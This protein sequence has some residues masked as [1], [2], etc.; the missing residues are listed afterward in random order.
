MDLNCIFAPCLPLYMVFG[1]VLVLRK[2][3]RLLCWYSDYVMGWMG[4]ELGFDSWRRQEIFLSP[5]ASRLAVVANQA[6]V[7]WVL[8]AFLCRDKVV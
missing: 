6:P 8:G 7:Q 5:K 1:I 2:E 4:V 3:S